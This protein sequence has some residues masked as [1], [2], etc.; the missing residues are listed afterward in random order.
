MKSKWS[1]IF[2]KNRF[3]SKTVVGHFVF[4]YLF[5]L[6]CSLKKNEKENTTDILKYSGIGVFK[7]AFMI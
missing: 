7:I 3:I 1:A 4:S 5:F 6:K 2:T